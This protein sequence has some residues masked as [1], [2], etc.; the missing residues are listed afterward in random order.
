MHRIIPFLALIGALLIA[1]C[2][3]STPSVTTGRKVIEDRIASESKGLI[4]L[5]SFKK[6][7]GQSFEVM[8]IKGYKMEYEARIEFLAD[9]MWGG[10]GGPGQVQG[11]FAAEPSPWKAR[12]ESNPAFKGKQQ[13]LKNQQ[14]FLTGTLT[15]EQTE[16][17]WRA[18]K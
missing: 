10:G 11:M 2:S 4:K 15:F 6:T 8:G 1:G 16:Q 5:V 9:C 13:A 12:N 3:S 17:G 7:N 18:S 14:P